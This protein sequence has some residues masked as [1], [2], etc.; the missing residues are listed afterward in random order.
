MWHTTDVKLSAWES[1][2]GLSLQ[3]ATGSFLEMQITRHRGISAELTQDLARVGLP[4]SS[5]AR[6]LD[7]VMSRL[8]CSRRW[9][10]QKLW[11]V[12]YSDILDWAASKRVGAYRSSFSCPNQKHKLAFRSESALHSCRI[13]LVPSFKRTYSSNIP[14]ALAPKQQKDAAMKIESCGVS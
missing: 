11:G 5:A 2:S 4:V 10:L 9:Q 6:S 3:P 13:G 7:V 1:G 8:F 14:L 12:K